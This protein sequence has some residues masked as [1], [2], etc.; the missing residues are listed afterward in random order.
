MVPS[1]EWLYFICD[2]ENRSISVVNGAIVKNAE[3][4]FLPQSPSGWQDI[5]VSF[6]T[7][8]KYFSLLR[9]FSVPLKF[10]NDGARIVR[11]YQYKGRGYEEELY[12]MILRWNPNVGIYQLEYKGKIAMSENEDDPDTGVT[13]GTIE[14]GILSYLTAN[15][16]ITYQIKCD[17]TN[18]DAIKTLFDGIRL[19]DKYNY[20]IVSLDPPGSAGDMFTMPTAFLNNEGDSVGILHGDQSFEAVSDGDFS[21]YIATSSNYLFKTSVSPIELRIKGSASIRTEFAGITDQE[22]CRIFFVTSTGTQ[23]TVLFNPASP[24]GTLKS[25][26]YDITIPLAAN[27][28]VFLFQDSDFGRNTTFETSMT[29]EFNSKAAPS[30]AWCLRPLTLLQNLVSKMTDGKY[31]A[32]SNY[33]RARN[34]VVATCGDAI[35]NT[36]RT[37]IPN[38]FIQTSFADF[39]QSYNAFYNLG[40]KVI[41]NVLWIEPKADLYSDDNTEIFDI[42]EIIDLTI[43]TATAYL[44]NT[45]KTGFPAQK[46]DER[47]GKYEFNGTTQWRLPVTSVQKELNLVSKYRGDGFGIEFIRANLTQKDTTDDVQS[48]ATVFVVNISDQNSF[49][50]NG[51]MVSESKTLV[52]PDGEEPAK[53]FIVG[54]Q[55]T[56]S[57]ALTNNGTFTVVAV[58]LSDIGSLTVTVSESVNTESFA[59]A[60]FTFAYFLVRRV[61]Y[62]D[63]SGVLDNTVYNIED[64]SPARQLRAHG[65]YIRSLLYQMTGE[66]VYFTSGDKNTNLSTTQGTTTISES[67]DVPLSSLAPPFYL[68]YIGS[69]KARVP[70]SFSAILN[71]VGK[72]HIKA[73][74]NGFP[75]YFLPIGDFSSK[76]ASPEAQEWK[77]MLSPKTPLDT[78]LRFSSDGLFITDYMENTLF[79]HDLNPLQFVKYN[80]TP[81][82]GY[83]DKDIYDD[84]FKNR[85]GR[86]VEQVDYQQKFQ[87]SDTISLQFI[88]AGLDPVEIQIYN[89]D[90]EQ[91][92][93]IAA[94]I[95]SNPSVQ[96]PYILQEVNI[97]LTAFDEGCY[98]FVVFANGIPLAISEW[99]QVA[100][101]WPETFKFDYYHTSNRLNAYFNTWRPSIRLEAFWKSWTDNSTFTDYQDENGNGEMLN[102]RPNRKRVLYVG[103]G[104]GVPEYVQLKVGEIMLL[105]RT[106]IE[107]TLYKRVSDGKIEEVEIAEGLPKQYYTLEVMRSLNRTGLSISDTDV[108][109]TNRT[110]VY[111]LDAKAFGQAD[112]VINIETEEV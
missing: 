29:I 39:Y 93:V 91:V 62:D 30:T 19:Y 4:T 48:D 107:G 38:Y 106:S 47:N 8:S 32:D 10:I 54:Q 6:G 13:V 87:T 44:I 27:E 35:R 111:T 88:T 43:T 41:D 5:T 23:Y 34:N 64:L 95:V 81:P 85:I 105:N 59:G 69:F 103:D 61:E 55:F 20:R 112:G 2:S 80:Y 46:Y 33:F 98:T 18:P 66:K 71:Y 73:T 74:Y 57:G 96:L 21:S 99:V 3:P 15:D 45:I 68:P 26:D 92:D 109:E 78:L 94:D 12:L 9:S 49:M 25:D 1:R 70:Y 56:V 63:I 31:T 79:I 24:A 16:G 65:N 90:A 104:Y 60:T 89:G 52:F 77:L 11:Y 36:D 53:W 101:D 58:N 110:A 97:D 22:F 67:S 14:G 51:I 84:W 50:A 82:A 100:E 102:G 75:V 108:P 37:V 28:S 76:P 7:N 86:Y 72:G 40:V 83:H 42:G 17:E